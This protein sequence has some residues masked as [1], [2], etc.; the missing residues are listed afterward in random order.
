[1]PFSE[2]KK[3]PSLLLEG[4]A[5]IAKNSKPRARVVPIEDAETP[6][7]QERKL[8]EIKARL[9]LIAQLMTPEGDERTMKE[10]RE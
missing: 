5:V 6:E 1:M 2:I 3:N 7:A 9:G 10:L 8:V 4:E